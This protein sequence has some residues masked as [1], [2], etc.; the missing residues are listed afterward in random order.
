MYS[1]W[2][3]PDADPL[4]EGKYARPRTLQDMAGAFILGMIGFMLL[5]GGAVLVVSLIR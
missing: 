2:G 3:G 1:P 4:L 5:L